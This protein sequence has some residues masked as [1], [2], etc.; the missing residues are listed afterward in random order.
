MSAKYSS[1]QLREMAR[2]ALQARDRMDPRYGRLV[3]A[4][5]M[6]FEISPAQVDN[7]IERLANG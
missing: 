6:R 2:Q 1:E 4:L 7:E 3:F 5:A